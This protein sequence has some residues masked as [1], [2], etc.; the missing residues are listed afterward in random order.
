[1]LG[2]IARIVCQFKRNWSQELEDDAIVRACEEVGHTWRE[3]ELGPV[4]TVKMFFLQ[5]LYGNVACEFV[6]HL[7]D[8]DVT[9]S[10]YCTARGRL[11]LAALQT[12]LTR[13][14]TK[15]AECVRDTGLWLGHRLFVLDGS[16]FSMPDTDQ[17]REQFGQP[18]GQAAGCGF[19]TAHWLALVHFGSGLFQKVITAPLRTHDMNGAAQLHPELGA[20]DVLLGDRAFGTFAHVALLIQRGLHGIFRAHQKLIIDFTPGRAHAVPGRGK[21]DH[22][23]GKP[24]SR[25]VE[26]LGPLDQI[27]EWLRPVEV[28]AWLTA[29]AWATLPE[30]IRVR[31]LR[32][33]IAQPGFRVRTVTLVTT[34]LDAVRY[35]KEKLAEA[36][37]LRWTIE[38]A[39]RHLKTTMKMDVLRC[40]T[41][42]G[43]Q[44][45]LTMFLLVYNLVRM[46]VL[47]A[48]R[49]QGVS[50]ERISFVDALRWLATAKPGDELPQLIVN[51]TRPGRVEPR[52]RKRRPK[53]FP[54]MK[55]PRAALQQELL[56]QS[57]G[58]QFDAI[59]LIPFSALAKY[60]RQIGSCLV[61]FYALTINECIHQT[62]MKRFRF[63]GVLNFDANTEI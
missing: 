33:T 59:R 17:L 9:G 41:V 4:A 43:I 25:W 21:S 53:E 49:R 29:E 58:A 40:Q 8:K 47:E 24:R 22:H 20:G 54:V 55:K 36:Y 35:P 61:D 63:F 6:P 30:M 37:G 57:F 2:N 23:T 56:T 42:P 1:V 15:M 5:I 31:E 48:A 12:L 14:R 13:C 11:P 16:S 27:V 19:P 18:G 10:A 32:Y 26:S 51:P 28:P 52:V 7:A 46:T 44:K 45:E 34:L 38:T 39:F 62:T 3:R 60:L 50:P